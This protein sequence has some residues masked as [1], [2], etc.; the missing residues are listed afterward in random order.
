MDARG[1]HVEDDDA[2]D[3]LAGVVAAVTLARF[4]IGTT[5]RRIEPPCVS[6]TRLD[7]RC[8]GGNWWHAWQVGA[9]RLSS[10]P[11]AIGPLA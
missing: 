10:L 2:V 7:A 5:V 8:A 6:M 9:W 3:A 1:V 11:D 4:L